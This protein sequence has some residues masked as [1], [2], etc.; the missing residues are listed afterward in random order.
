MPPSPTKERTS[1][2]SWTMVSGVAALMLSHAPG[3]FK[4]TEVRQILKQ[5]ANSTAFYSRNPEYTGRLGSGRL[6]AHA[7]LTYVSGLVSHNPVNASA[8]PQS[9][10]S[11]EITWQKNPQGHDVLLAHVPDGSYPRPF[12]GKTYVVGDT[13]GTRGAVVLYRGPATSY[14]HS[15]LSPNT[16]YQYRL[17]SVNSNQYSIGTGVQSMTVP[18]PMNLTYQVSGNNVTL[19]WNQ[20]GS[21]LYTDA[22]AE[23]VFPFGRTEAGTFRIAQRYDAEFLSGA[24]MA[25]RRLE[26]ISFVPAAPPAG[27]APGS[28]PI[29]TL[30]VWTQDSHGTMTEVLS[31][32]VVQELNYNT[33]NVVALSSPVTIPVGAALWFG[34]E[35]AASSWF[36]AGAERGPAVSG[37]GDLFYFEEEWQSMYTRLGVNRNFLIRGYVGGA[38]AGKSEEMLLASVDGIPGLK[39]HNNVLNG[40]RIYRGGV[41][42][43]EVTDASVT[44]YTDTNRPSGTYTYYVT[45]VFRN[46]DNESGPSNQ[47]V[48][49]VP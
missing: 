31:Q 1:Q 11:I 24:M 9:D 20:P 37:R 6:D 22:S 36:P 40:Y 42:I 15:G 26:K 29:F 18:P 34:Y 43:H 5:T 44:S 39:S 32:L 30:K 2:R 33:W 27:Y 7:A 23:D 13:I 35:V 25:G 17:W 38:G 14:L 8:S 28:A 10:V 45:S 16:T 21:W 19:Q 41:L 47:V 12:P 46:P 48:V 49:T 3:V 4:A